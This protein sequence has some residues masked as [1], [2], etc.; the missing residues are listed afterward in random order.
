MK[1]SAVA[2]PCDRKKLELLTYPYPD[3]HYSYQLGLYIN[4]DDGSFTG[5]W[6]KDGRPLVHQER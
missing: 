3:D 1:K 5:T 6:Y 4:I 2:D